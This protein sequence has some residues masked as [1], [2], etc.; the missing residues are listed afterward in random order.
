MNN[1]TKNRFQLQIKSLRG[2]DFQHFIRELYL[3]KYGEHGFTVLRDTKDKG[4][5]GIIE[6][7]QRVIACFGPQEISNT[8]K[9]QREFDNKVEGDYNEYEN[10]WKSQYPNWSFIINHEIDP[11]YDIKAKSLYE[12]ANIIGITQILSIVENLKSYQ[13]RKIG[14]YLNIESEYLTSDYIGEILEDLLKEDDTNSDG[15]SYKPKSLIEINDKI[16]INYNDN[17]IEE[18]KNEYGL[19]LEEGTL[20]EIAGILHGY[21]DDEISKIK[22]RV[23]YDYG[24][25]TGEFKSRLDLLTEHYLVKYSDEN[26]DDYLFYIRA[27]LIYFFEQCLIGEKTKVENDITTSRK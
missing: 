27:I 24:T 19:L 15:I 8:K 5:D 4:C 1:P 23:I 13:R 9:R 18:V 7:E 6:G 17:D 3:V 12:K 2:F 25:K 11:H 16:D 21:E 22:K 14:K 20:I 10:N 26:D